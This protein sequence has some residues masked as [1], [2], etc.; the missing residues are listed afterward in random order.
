[1]SLRDLIRDTSAQEG[2]SQQS[3]T[4]VRDVVSAAVLRKKFSHGGSQIQLEFRVFTDLLNWK[5]GR[6]SFLF[7]S[8]SEQSYICKS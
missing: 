3:N 8:T 4:L 1:M 7:A 5:I 6:C 2:T